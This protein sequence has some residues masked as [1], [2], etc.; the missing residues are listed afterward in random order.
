M[1]EVFINYKLD[2]VASISI[3]GASLS[4]V[5]TN[6]KLITVIQLLFQSNTHLLTNVNVGTP[7][8][9]QVELPFVCVRGAGH[10]S[11][12]SICSGAQLDL[13]EYV[14]DLFGWTYLSRINFICWSLWRPKNLEAF[15][16]GMD[17]L[18][19]FTSGLFWGNCF[20]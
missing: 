2:N 19:I 14:R 5:V 13:H 6:K 20:G 3:R 16:W 15:T 12:V 1:N 11:P 8:I 17:I 7:W 10:N 9:N 4:S 18:T